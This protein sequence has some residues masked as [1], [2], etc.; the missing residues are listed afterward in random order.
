MTRTI[1]SRWRKVVAGAGLTA[2]VILG[3]WFW[4]SA[5]MPRAALA[6]TG[7][8]F[9]GMK[10][11]PGGTFTMGRD[12]G[13]VIVGLFGDGLIEGTVLFVES[14]VLKFGDGRKRL[15]SGIVFGIALGGAANQ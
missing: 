12:N 5:T 15:Q 10:V 14:G 2:T 7:N 11:V 6:Q 1:G 4:H 3:G 8:L 9:T 13:H